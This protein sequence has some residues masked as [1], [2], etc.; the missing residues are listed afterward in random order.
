MQ[1]TKKQWTLYSKFQILLATRSERPLIFCHYWFPL[2]IEGGAGEEQLND[3]EDARNVE[4]Q[5]EDTGNWNFSCNK[6]AWI[7]SKQFSLIAQTSSFPSILFLS[8][9]ILHLLPLNNHR[10]N[11]MSLKEY[12]LDKENTAWY[13]WGVQYFWNYTQKCPTW[14]IW[15]EPV[16]VLWRKQ[17]CFSLCDP[18]A[19]LVTGM[20]MLYRSPVCCIEYSQAHTHAH[21]HKW[22]I[23]PSNGL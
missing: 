7:L 10:P 6:C 4:S 17:T 15:F 11:E 12:R 22:T 3:A 23:R 13:W 9:G 20:P 1:E 2:G 14:L 21:T 16:L 8:L 5:V 18:I 19:S